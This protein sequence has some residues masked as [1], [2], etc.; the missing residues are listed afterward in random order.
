M[1]LSSLCVEIPNQEA[2]LNHD[3]NSR[4]LRER[5]QLKNIILN[6]EKV[7]LKQTELV[8]LGHVVSNQGVRPNPVKVAAITK[9]LSP[10][11]VSGVKR[12]CGMVQY[13]PV[14]SVLKWLFLNS[15]P[16][17]EPRTFATS[18]PLNV[19]WNWTATC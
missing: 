14:L 5:C 2:A 13:L 3:D 18:D 10:T 8:F 6:D 4:N 9:L 11:D 19:A 1:T 15:C 12:F 7:I 17:C 16:I